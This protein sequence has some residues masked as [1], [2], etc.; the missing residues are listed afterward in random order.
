[1]R[2]VNMSLGGLL[3]E[4]EHRVVCLVYEGE[5]LPRN[6]CSITVVLP[7]WTQRLSGV[8][9][10]LAAL[11][12][13][14]RSLNDPA[15]WAAYHL[16][17][18]L[19]GYEIPYTLA[20]RL[21]REARVEPYGVHETNMAAYWRGK[22]RALLALDKL[23]MILVRVKPPKDRRHREKLRHT[24]EGVTV[25]AGG[26]RRRSRGL[27]ERLG[28]KKIAP[29]LYLVFGTTLQELEKVVK[30]HGGSIEVVYDPT[31]TAITIKRKSIATR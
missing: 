10:E 5:E 28:G 26:R 18:L 16:A 4:N 2:K 15:A 17:A 3:P 6:G 24:L 30:E 22:A 31:T 23:R 1:L 27:V 11:Y 8:A 12:L 29:W 25:T 9:Q 19:Q 21:A 7:E 14:A 20:A 13:A